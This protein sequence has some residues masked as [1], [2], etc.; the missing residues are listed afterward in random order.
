MGQVFSTC[1]YL[2]SPSQLRAQKRLDEFQH[3]VGLVS[4]TVPPSRLLNYVLTAKGPRMLQRQSIGST[5][6]RQQL[7]KT[8]VTSVLAVVRHILTELILCFPPSNRLCEARFACVVCL[9]VKKGE[10]RDRPKIGIV[11]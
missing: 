10:D 9:R 5:S 8:K 11:W 1:V 2:F 3:P 4:S 7:G 6:N